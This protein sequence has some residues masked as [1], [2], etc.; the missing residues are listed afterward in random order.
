MNVRVRMCLLLL[1]QKYLTIL[2]RRHE[3]L[4]HHLF[5][6]HF[7]YWDSCSVEELEADDDVPQQHVGPFAFVI[8]W[9]C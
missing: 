9:T 3:D 7:L 4:H 5:H 6:S 8:L 2:C 1:C